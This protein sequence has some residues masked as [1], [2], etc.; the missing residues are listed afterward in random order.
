[1]IKSAI[2]ILFLFNILLSQP[3]DIKFEHLG[4]EHG[5]SQSTVHCIIQDRKGFM[6]FGTSDGLNKYDGYKFTLYKNDPND[7]LSLSHNFVRALYEDHLGELWIGTRNGGVCRYDRN[8]DTFIRYLPEKDNPNSLPSDVITVIY[9]SEEK[10]QYTLWIGGAKGIEKYNRETDDFTRYL[11]DENDGVESIT[12]NLSGQIWIGNW[13]KGLYYFDSE[14]NKFIKYRPD[15][16]YSNMFRNHLVGNYSLHTSRL[17]ERNILW[18]NVEGNGFYKIDLESGYV[19]HFPYSIAG[20][21]LKIYPN[22]NNSEELWLGTD[23]ELTIFNIQTGEFTHYR[24]QPENKWSL[25]GNVIWSIF[26]DKSGLMWL[27]TDTQGINKFEP[28]KKRFQTIQ[29]Q[30]A[31]PDGLSGK[32]VKAILESNEG[33]DHSILWIGTLTEGLNRL[34]RKTKQ[35]TKYKHEPANKN[36]LSHNRIMAISESQSGNRQILWVSTSGGLNKIDLK[37]QQITRYYIPG[38]DPGHHGIMTHCED[39]NG[40]IWIGT[41]NAYLFSFNPETEQFTRYGPYMILTQTLFID[42]SG[43]LWVGTGDGLYKFN[44]ETKEETYYVHIDGDVKSISNNYIYSIFEDKKGIL[45]IGTGG[46][47]NKFDRSTE[48]FSHFTEND[49]L[50]SNVVKGILEDGHDNIWLSTTKGISKF[51]P[52][53]ETF[54]NFDAA[55]GLQGDEFITGAYHK[56]QQ[57]EMFFGGTNGLTT[58]HPDSIKNNIYI[59]PITITDFQIFNKSVKPGNKSPLKKQV[60]ETSEIALSHDQSIFSFEFAALDYHNPLKNQYKYKMEGV[61]PDWV[62]TDASRRF[63]TY[64]NLDPGDYIF[65][66]RGSNNDGI[67][68]DEGTSIKIIITPPWWQSN[69]AYAFYGLLIFVAIFLARKYDLNRINLRNESN[70]LKEIDQLKSRFF[71]NISHEFRTPLTLIL[72]PIQKLLEDHPT[73]DENNQYS[74]IQRN[75][76]RLQRL[77]NQLLDISCQRI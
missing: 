65:R 8:Q 60:S 43:M 24:H 45:W 53:S 34:D 42:S 46:G 44:I 18:T 27:G 23:Q 6:W 17:G 63:A 69:W 16:K 40:I 25:K 4:I 13:N 58:F 77:I 21:I 37:T 31:N 66:V 56:N 1:M 35:I 30:A 70:R 61:D 29:E 48:T 36:S 76:L 10:D 68:N 67:W 49:G 32:T 3:S 2:T 14:K 59:P 20:N 38:K 28:W 11:P 33:G 9:E 39:K 64:T 55:D 72:G 15:S 47:L 22:R 5:L 7:T 57:G 26:Q 54:R 71:A 75:A 73:A 19:T 50:P 12:Q 51:N 62:S 74:L 52:I 41:P